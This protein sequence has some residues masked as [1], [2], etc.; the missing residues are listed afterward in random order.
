MDVTIPSLTVA[1][2]GEVSVITALINLAYRGAG[3]DAG[4]TTEAELFQGN[5]TS[6]E[7]LQENIDAN[8]NAALLV[9]RL[10]DGALL[11]CVW[12]EPEDDH[13]WYLG[14][15][16]I[17]PRQQNRGL[18]RKLLAAA[19]DWVRERGGREIRMTVVNVRD[20]LLGWYTRR[21]YALTGEA[22]PF[23][24]GDNR[25]GIPKR[26]DLHFVVLRKRL[27]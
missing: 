13:I 1:K 26:D 9:W 10:P 25:F 14:S 5:R 20:T 12:L 19:E 27:S 22:E 21:G 24:Y 17:D 15:L 2:T 6:E 23:P 4:W 8:V 18:G 16:S 3:L 11:G 7:L